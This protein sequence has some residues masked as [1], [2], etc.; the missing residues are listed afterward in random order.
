MNETIKLEQLKNLLQKENIDFTI[1]TDEISLAT[2]QSGANQYGIALHE[3]APT[4][5]LKTKDG[6]LAAIIAGNTKISFKKLKHA[7]DVKDISMA[8]PQTIKE[9]TGATI[10]EVCLINLDVPTIVDEAVLK[11]TYCYGGSGAPKTTLKIN[12][13]DLMRITNAQVLDFTEPRTF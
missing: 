3:A 1:L 8:D 4:L 10:G 2:A 13:Q 5:I 9:I 7:L 12:T 6:Y 11:N